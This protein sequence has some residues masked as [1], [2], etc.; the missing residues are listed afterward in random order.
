MPNFISKNKQLIAIILIG[1]L[2]RLVFSVFFNHIFDFRN[3]LAIVKSV[4]LTGDVTEG[5]FNLKK[6]GLE[7]QLYGKLYYQ[8][9]ALWFH[10]LQLI[11]ILDISSFD[12]LNIP[13]YQLISIKFSQFLYDFIFLYFFYRIAQ[14]L[15]INTLLACLFWALNPY[16]VFT[17]YAMYQSDIAMLSF[18]VGGVYFALQAIH[19]KNQKIVYPIAAIIFFAIGASLKQVPILLIPLTIIVFSK[20]YKYLLTLILV[21]FLS[22]FISSQP[23]GADSQFIRLFFLISKE[24]TALFNFQ[25]NSIPLFIILYL[26]LML[27]TFFKRNVILANPP[28]FLI[29]TTLLL[30]I[31]YL[32]E[33]NSFFFPQFNIW[34][35]PF[36][37]LLALSK[38]EYTIF[39][40]TPVIGFFKRQLIDNDFLTGAL[41]ESI[42]KPLA[43]IPRYDYLLKSVFNPTLIDYGLN[44]L[45]FFLYVLLA[46]LLLSEFNILQRIRQALITL[47]E[48]IKKYTTSIILG[49]FALYFVF[50][51]I[52]YLIKSQYVLFNSG[53]YQET[54]MI[55]KVHTRPVSLHISNPGEGNIKGLEI[56]SSRNN[57]SAYDMVN[58]QF[59]DESTGKTILKQQ[60][61]DY[62]FPENADELFI[63]LKKSINAKEIQL[64]ISKE[65][66]QN[67][68]SFY[69]AR[70]AQEPPDIMQSGIKRSDILNL[71]YIDTPITIDIRGQYPLMY[72]VYSLGKHILQKPSFYIGY[73][74]LLLALVGSIIVLLRYKP[75]HTL[76]S[77]EA[78]KEKFN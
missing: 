16:I 68:L 54:G 25:L 57:I 50:L 11:N 72:I 55:Y 76:I 65:T 24:S 70:L 1:V 7:V 44:G 63:P 67:D 75:H 69:Q 4:A 21:T 30:V 46:L 5:F 58:L 12:H 22:Y 31:I 28:L 61:S 53:V 39:F 26:S 35:M 17:T 56:K 52:D 40:I 6:L 27:L 78:I 32:S 51:G 48:P 18:M 64:D 37:I 71:T 59:I 9:A 49:I 33:D 20:N 41:S 77:I 34:V 60:V 19:F 38:P 45:L 8:I 42:G 73:A 14:L 43:N 74:I 23:W 47:T 2:F 13:L 29:L 62:L 15:K 3:I 66:G 36:I 10:F